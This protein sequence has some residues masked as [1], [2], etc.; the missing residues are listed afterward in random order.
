MRNKI[1]SRRDTHSNNTRY[2]KQVE[3]NL[4]SNGA[5]DTPQTKNIYSSNIS[6]TEERQQHTK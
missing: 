3:S 1:Q 5:Y 4:E 2:S 6:H